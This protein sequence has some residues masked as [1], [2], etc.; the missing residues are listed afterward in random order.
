MEVPAGAVV[1][2]DW[3]VPQ[4][5]VGSSPQAHPHGLLPVLRQPEPELLRGDGGVS[6]P[7]LQADL[8]QRVDRVDGTGKTFNKL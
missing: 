3:L 6:L 5:L 1:L 7:G 4:E 8:F 2:G